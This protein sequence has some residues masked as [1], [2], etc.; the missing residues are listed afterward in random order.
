MEYKDNKEKYTEIATLYYLGGYSQEKIGAIYNISRFKVSRV[1]QKC[2]DLKIVEININKN[3]MKYNKLAEGIK[4]YF[5]LKK[6]IITPV[7][8]STHETKINV[9]KAASAFLEENIKNGMKIGISWGSTIQE[10]VNEFNPKKSC[11]DCVFVQ[12]SGNLCSKSI[13]DEGYMDGSEIVRKIAEKA[14]AGWS[15]FQVPYIVNKMELKELL[16]EDPNIKGHISLF[17]KLNIALIGVGSDKPENSVSFRSGYI[18]LEES[19]SLINKGLGADVAGIRLLKNGQP[20]AHFL[21]G[22]VLTIEPNVMQK[23]PC[24]VALGAGEEKVAS[25]M[26][27]ARGGYINIMIIDEVTAL[28]II[29]VIQ[30]YSEITEPIKSED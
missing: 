29:N 6:V 26:A 2:M 16:C 30:K 17:E 15:L 11:E 20:S 22:R 4:E 19:T 14:K 21:S 13:N 10:L 9:A 23:I 24:V 5:K 18:T 1:L 25:L 28:A 12:L 27:G 8:H 3:A 7:G